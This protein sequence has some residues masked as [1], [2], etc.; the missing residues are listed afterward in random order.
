M[1]NDF[2]M[3]NNERIQ[4]TDE[5]QTAVDSERLHQI[6]VVK[7]VQKFKELRRDRNQLL[8][9]TDYIFGS[10]APDMS[11]EKIIEWRTYRQSLRDLPANTSDPFNITWPTK[12]S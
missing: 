6:N 5:E 9:D 7:P 4:L 10:D 12:P 11:D 1:P 2:H 3:I 8:N